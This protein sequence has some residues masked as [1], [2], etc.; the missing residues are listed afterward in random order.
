MSFYTNI[1]TD[2]AGLMAM[3][4]KHPD[5]QFILSPASK[6]GTPDP[7]PLLQMDHTALYALRVNDAGVIVAAAT[8]SDESSQN[9]LKLQQ[10]STRSGYKRAGHGS[11]MVHLMFGHA[12]GAGRVLA[13]TPF[14]QD[15]AAAA[16]PGLPDLHV[17]HYPTLKILYDGQTTPVAGRSRY[18][19]EYTPCGLVPVF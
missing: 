16:V 13:L 3:A 19:L 18:R 5:N 4:A 10:V 14:E 17:T 2:A 11:V 7:M 15:G 8:Y 6:R 12:A 1:F 9:I